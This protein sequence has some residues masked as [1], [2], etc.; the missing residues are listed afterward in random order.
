MVFRSNMPKNVIHDVPDKNV[1]LKKGQNL[2]F[3]IKFILVINLKFF[4]SLFFI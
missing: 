2:L 4:Y 1:K 3:C